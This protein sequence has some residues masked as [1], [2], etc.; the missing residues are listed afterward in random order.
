[1]PLI[2]VVE[3]SGAAIES[4]RS[5]ISFSAIFAGALAMASSSL[6]L[7]FVG[8]GMGFA[9]A[10]PWSGPAAAA[11]KF[12]ATTAIALVV[13]QWFSSGIGGYIAGRLRVKWAAV[14]DDQ[15]F[16]EDTAHGFLAWSLAMLAAAFLFAGVLSAGVHGLV[17]A[18]GNSS[19][20]AQNPASAAVPSLTSQVDYWTDELLRSPQVATNSGDAHAE[21]GR[22]LFRGLTGDIPQTDR[23]Y[24]AQLVSARAGVDQGEAKKRIDNVTQQID[25]AKRAATEFA[26]QTR[27][28]AAT[29][30]LMT[31]LALVVGAFI[32]SA[33]AALG[34]RR[35]DE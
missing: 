3:R 6:V 29:T 15:I 2:N 30:S 19:Q 7:V 28:T 25:E 24:A 33:A 8:A 9:V 5:A 35:R 27:K 10:T 13:I 17:G 23:D 20:G 32:A 18:A 1:M 14:H 21:L 12:A 22:I 4:S 11:T 16:F 34:G 31:A 26:D